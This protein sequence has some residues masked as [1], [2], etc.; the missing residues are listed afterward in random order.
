M[1]G[2]GATGG[3]SYAALGSLPTNAWMPPPIADA[4]NRMKQPTIVVRPRL[5][6][7]RPASISIPTEDTAT[8]ATVV[9][10]EPSKVPCSHVTAA[11]SALDPAGSERETRLIP[12]VLLRN[13][14]L[15]LRKF[16]SP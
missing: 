8:T 3:G 12:L 16:G 5:I 7:S 6:S 10:T 9:A 15:K 1:E 14:Y 4:P 13:M 11:T 2:G